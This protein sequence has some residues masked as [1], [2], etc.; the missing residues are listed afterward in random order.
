MIYLLNSYS[1]FKIYLLNIPELS[2]DETRDDSTRGIWKPFGS[3]SY[4]LES[5]IQ[6]SACHILPCSF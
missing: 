1:F 3:S 2:L 6:D 4:F 5:Y